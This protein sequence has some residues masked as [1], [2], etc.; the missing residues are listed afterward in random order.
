[1]SSETRKE[2]VREYSDQ[3]VSEYLKTF[4]SRN[5]RAFGEAEKENICVQVQTTDQSDLVGKKNRKMSFVFEDS[6]CSA[7]LAV[8]G[9]SQ[10]SLEMNSADERRKHRY[11][12]Y[13]SRKIMDRIN[14]TEYHKMSLIESIPVI[15]N[16]SH[17]LCYEFVILG[18]TRNRYS[19]RIDLEP[20]CSCPDFLKHLESCKHILYVFLKVLHC[21]LKNPVI[22]QKSLLRE[23]LKS[24]L[25]NAASDSKPSSH[26]SEHHDRTSR[27]AE[28]LE[29]EHSIPS[30]EELYPKTHLF[31]THSRRVAAE[32]TAM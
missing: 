9:V 29:P 7:P 11:R 15:D 20:S 26:K 2:W 8:S 1:M 24:V 10:H 25:G 28:H 6:N 4:Q 32:L 12:P 19:V 30:L 13:P 18:A 14:R 5:S 27:H 22:W 21:S 3:L 17:E 31:L 23:E 16:S